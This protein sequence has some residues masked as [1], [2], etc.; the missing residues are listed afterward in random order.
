MDATHIIELFIFALVAV[1]TVLAV[2]AMYALGRH[3][4]YD[5]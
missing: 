1:G 4:S 2:G 5:D 3:S